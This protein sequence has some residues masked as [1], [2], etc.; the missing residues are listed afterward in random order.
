[1]PLSAD[2]LAEMK[3]ALGRLTART[4][5]RA[6]WSHESSDST[7]GKF[8]NGKSS[9][10]VSV[11][12]AQD[13]GTFR[14]EMS[15]SI[16]RE[17]L[18]SVSAADIANDL[19]F[20]HAFTELLDSGTVSEEK[21][22]TWNGTPARLVVLQLKEPKHERQIT[23]GKVSFAENRLS[24]WIGGDDVPLAAEHV[25]KASAGFL[26]FHG[27]ST[28]RESWQFARKD[29]HFVI[30]RREAWTSFSGLG[31]QGQVHSIVTVAI[32]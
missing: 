2:T 23:I 16:T 6:T 26:M 12:A 28:M 31:Q 19:D 8:A 14:V 5:L 7:S 15:R 1:M 29:D 20:A 9:R 18:S 11:E 27:D 24:V 13:A 25:R 17:A 30:A 3:T 21:R 4:P 22:V 10:H 32:H